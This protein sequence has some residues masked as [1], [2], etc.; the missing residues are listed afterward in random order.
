MQL[1]FHANV[2]LHR[3]KVR[4]TVVGDGACIA[5]GVDEIDIP[6]QKLLHRKKIACRQI[7]HRRKCSAYFRIR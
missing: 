6:D 7:I 3:E 1:T 4:H 2:F 5:A